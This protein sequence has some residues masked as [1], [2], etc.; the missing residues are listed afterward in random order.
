MI[1]KSLKL[2]NWLII[3]VFCYY[4]VLLLKFYLLFGDIG[5]FLFFSIYVGLDLV[6]F[7]FIE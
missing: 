5:F 6:E 2:L 1:I 7:V 4:M 3:Y